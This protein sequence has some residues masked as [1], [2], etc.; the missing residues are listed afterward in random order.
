M[1]AAEAAAIQRNASPVTPTETWTF[2]NSEGTAEE[3]VDKLKINILSLDVW[4]EIDLTHL[5][6]QAN[7]LSK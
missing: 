1:S 5:N 6:S 3:H 4:L 7:V 2:P